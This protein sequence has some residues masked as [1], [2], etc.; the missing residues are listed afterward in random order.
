MIQE[1]NCGVDSAWNLRLGFR[2][3]SGFEWKLKYPGNGNPESSSIIP[4]GFDN[5]APEPS[6]KSVAAEGE[7]AD[8]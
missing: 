3:K 6:T 8:R 5:S 1:S 2:S 7:G 4:T